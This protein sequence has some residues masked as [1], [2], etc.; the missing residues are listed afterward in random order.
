MVESTIYC[1]IIVL[2]KVSIL[3]QYITVFVV[4]RGNAFHIMVHVLLWTNVVFY[5]IDV[6][7]VT[8]EC[9]PRAKAWDNSIPGTCF[10]LHQL[11]IS[12]GIINVISDFA[13]LLLPLQKIWRLQMPWQKKWRILAVFA[14][15]LF[16]C[17][18]AVLR[19]VY[20]VQLTQVPANAFLKLA[21]VT[22]KKGLW[23]FAEIAL[24]IIAGCMPVLPRFFHQQVF[25]NLSHGSW[26]GRGKSSSG[27]GRK[28]SE[29]TLLQRVFGLSA[30]SGGGRRRYPVGSTKVNGGSSG[31]KSAGMLGSKESK[32]VGGNS[33]QGIETQNLTRASMELSGTQFRKESS[34][35]IS[36]TALPLH[37]RDG[38]DPSL[39]A[40][41]GRTATDRDTRWLQM[42]KA[43]RAELSI[44]GDRS[45][46]G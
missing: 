38:Q 16:G 10:S 46:A 37:S 13:I 35:D 11:G 45:T 44:P 40:L 2:V 31:G 12:S 15:G 21:L 34:P 17:I 9:K 33:F 25:I 20:S 29:R 14:V 5:T 4:H 27:G 8:F 30:S 42:S 23:G 24:G 6:L 39:P 28:S 18:A 36:L 3:L 7:L 32:S 22:D 43:E 1:P 19:L 41:P 26:S